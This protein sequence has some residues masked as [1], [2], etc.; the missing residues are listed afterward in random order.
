MIPFKSASYQKYFLIFLTTCL[1]LN[2]SIA[3]EVYSHQLTH[4]PAKQL[5]PVIQPH[6]S[7]KAKLTANGFKLFVSGTEKDN[8][9]VS[10]LLAGLDIPFKEYLVELQITKQQLN[11]TAKNQL[12]LN[13]Q[14]EI[15]ENKSKRL[16]IGHAGSNT[17]RF[18]LRVIENFQAFITTGESFPDTKFIS[19]YDQFIP[20]NGRRKVS[21][22]FYLTVTPSE[23][24]MVQLMASAFQQQTQ[25]RDNRNVN[26]SSTSSQIK[27]NLNEWTLL[28]STTTETNKSNHKNYRHHANSTKDRFYYIR[29][30]LMSDQTNN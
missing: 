7:D 15:R 26:L 4:Q 13:K 3:A 29:V 14:T 27:A 6:L 22:G 5:I 21:R 28:A 1:N 10:R 23:S 9:A 18:K 19:Q 12:D 30:R 11:L 25:V 8:N 2:S 24:S 20:S 16:S 17:N